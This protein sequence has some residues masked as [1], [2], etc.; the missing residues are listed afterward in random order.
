MI[1]HHRLKCF[2]AGESHVEQMLPDLI[3]RGRQPS[4]GITVH[5]ATITLRVTAAA[6]T[7]EACRAAM[8]PTLATIR[9]KLGALVFGEEDDELEDATIRLLAERGQTLATVELG[10]GGQLA[11]WLARRRRWPRQLFGRASHSR[12]A[13]AGSLFG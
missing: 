9:E 4:V 2:G 7:A 1:R 8:E 6:A 3:R 12:P 10:T 5:A 11:E 13:N